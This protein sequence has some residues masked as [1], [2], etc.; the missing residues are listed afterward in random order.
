MSDDAVCE[1]LE[2]AS[3]I[4]ITKG[5]RI[6]GSQEGGWVYPFG[7][8]NYLPS[9]TEYGPTPENIKREATL[10]IPPLNRL[11]KAGR[12]ERKFVKL[13]YRPGVSAPYPMYRPL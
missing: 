6:D 8:L 5:L 12:A 9:D 7:V 2:H 11:V 13:K 3:Y 10:L 1:A 4:S